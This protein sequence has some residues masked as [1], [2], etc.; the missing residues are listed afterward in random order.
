MND[1]EPHIIILAAGRGTR[2]RS[3]V[4]KVLHPVLF[5]PMLHHVLD[6][7]AE[8]PHRSV[9]LVV[10]HGEAQV[11]QSC[12]S[13]PDLR[14]FTQDSPLGTGHA[15]RMTEP[16]LAG[17]KGPVLVL[18]GDVVLT[19]PESLREL[20]ARHA[21]GGFQCTVGTAV[22]AEPFGYGRILSRGERLVAI[23]E[24]KDCSEAERLVDEVNSGI[25][26]FDAQALFSSLGRVTNANRQGEYYLTDTVELL[27]GR[28]GGV[29]RFRFSDHEEMTGINDHEALAR[30]EAL[31]RSRFNRRLM[32]EGV[33]LQD[34]ASSYIDVRCRIEPD[35]RI[36]AGC[37]IVASVVRSGARIESSCRIV[38]SE[39]GPGAQV[40]QGSYLEKSIVGAGCQLGPYAHLRPG[41]VLGE[42]CKVGNFVETK[43][44]VFGA[45]SKASHL[46]YIGDAEIG[47]GVN[48]GCGFITCNYDGGPVKLRTVIEDGAFIG[49]D[50]QAVAPVRIGAGSYIATGTTVTEDVP[51]GALALSRGRQ[52]TKP[53]YAKKYRKDPDP[54]T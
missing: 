43:N 51:P 11:R 1:K 34:P 7:A 20:L 21:Q 39:I 40:K 47:R 32:L 3:S 28:R 53:D 5:R 6:L 23:R 36:E 22:V 30:V 37:T 52:V 49:S 31:M 13:Y 26:C 8:L 25:Y 42:G 17:Q 14:Y 29:G 33:S 19:R 24:E 9:S 54:K 16:F 44:S 4:P 15:V 41:T 45:G 35:V 50:S 46:S 27:A 38:G 12:A 2:M 10:G 48:V 18:C